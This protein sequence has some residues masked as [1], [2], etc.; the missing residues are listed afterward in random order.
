VSRAANVRRVTPTQDWTRS[1][2]HARWRKRVELGY[3]NDFIIC[4]T[5]SSKT[6][7]SGTG[8]TTLATVLAKHFDKSEDGFSAEE[9]A[10]LDSGHLAYDIIPGI[11]SK[12]AV[13]FDEAQGAP[14]TDSVNARRGMKSEALD[15]I[16]AILANRDKSLTLILVG[17]QLNMLDKNLYPMIDAWVLIRKG[18]DEPQ[19]PLATHH[20]IHTNDYDLSSST[21]KTPGVEDLTWPPL[22]KDDPDYVVMEEKKQK[23][24]LRRA[25]SA[26]DDDE[27]EPMGIPDTL[28]DMPMKHR[29]AVI[30]DLRA[31]GVDREKVAESAG[32]DPTR[33]SQIT[34]GDN[35]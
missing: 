8:K 14:G 33:V 13:I 21:P 17:Q 6:G 23:A 12:S 15:A 22:P 35:E 31:R 2:L 11:D 3:A 10:T 20:K 19:G 27:G 7:V 29:D 26:G 25:Q 16:N 1:R 5:P 18:P 4:V 30:R 34:S 32:I 24:K 28:A 9:K